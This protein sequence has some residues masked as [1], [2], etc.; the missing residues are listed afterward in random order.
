MQESG[1]CIFVDHGG[2]Y[3]RG[4]HSN[5]EAVPQ[6]GCG[7]GKDRGY[8]VKTAV[9]DPADAGVFDHRQYADTVHWLQL[10]GYDHGYRKTGAV[11]YSCDPDPAGVVWYSGT[12]ACAAHSGPSDLSADAG[13]CDNGGKGIEGDGYGYE[14]ERAGRGFLRICHP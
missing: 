8:G 7:G 5:H 4:V 1:I 10:P 11:F 3:V 12:A 13:H 2:H 14:K 9:C 6:R